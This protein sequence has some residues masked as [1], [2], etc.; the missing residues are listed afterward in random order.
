M[1][2]NSLHAS[3]TNHSYAVKYLSH[4]TVKTINN[5]APIIINKIHTHGLQGFK[6]YIKNSFIQNYSE[7]CD[8]QDG[9]THH[10]Q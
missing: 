6:N 10:Q 3:N 1:H 4:R 9:Y 8:I 5:R 2:K 7:V